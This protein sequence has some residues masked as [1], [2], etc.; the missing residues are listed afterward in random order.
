MKRQKN[1]FIF[2]LDGFLNRHAAATNIPPIVRSHL[3][4]IVQSIYDHPDVRYVEGY[5]MTE[6]IAAMVNRSVQLLDI[7]QMPEPRM[8]EML[9][10]LVGLDSAM[11]REFLREA[12]IE[13]ASQ[14]PIMLEESASPRSQREILLAKRMQ[15]MLKARQEEDPLPAS[16]V[17]L[18]QRMAHKAIASETFQQYRVD[19]MLD[20]FAE[21]IAKADDILEAQVDGLAAKQQLKDT[22][23]EHGPLWKRFKIKAPL[24]SEVV[25]EAP[26]ETVENWFF[27]PHLD[28]Q[29]TL[30]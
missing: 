27:V 22:I 15:R 8:V 3:C 9:D 25:E 11:V 13:R 20:W 12:R 23:D 4:A 7:G 30:H 5:K 14:E 26:Q 16:C 18:M 1:D 19:A 2:L 10:Q 21:I 28:G 6:L 17:L 24:H 29:P